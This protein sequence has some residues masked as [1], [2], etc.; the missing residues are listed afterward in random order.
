[1]FMKKR[2]TFIATLLILAC[3]ALAG[4]SAWAAPTMKP[5][6]VIVYDKSDP[7][8]APYT[9]LR[10]DK[11]MTVYYE[12]TGYSSVLGAFDISVNVFKVDKVATEDSDTTYK[13]V[14]HLLINATTPPNVCKL[15]NGTIKG[16]FLLTKKI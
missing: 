9:M 16:S 15:S 8:Q 11:N 10:V 13:V 7:N 12:G 2:I 14:N 3:V 1:M 6:D 5:E 4:S